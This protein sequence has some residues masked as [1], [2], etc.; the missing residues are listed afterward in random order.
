VFV[1]QINLDIDTRFTL[2]SA[3]SA[4]DHQKYHVD[5][6]NELTP[7]ALLFV[8]GRTLRAI[9][10]V[11]AIVMATRIIHGR[12]ISLEC[13]VVEMT[14]IRKGREFEDLD[15]TNKEEGIEKM[16]GAKG[17]FILWPHKDIILKT[18][19]SSILQNRED[20]GT[21]TSENTLRNN[22]GFTPPSQNPPQTAS[23]HEDPP[24]RQPLQHHSPPHVA[25]SKCSPHTTVTPQNFKFWNVTKIH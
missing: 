9:K 1:P 22:A 11:D 12:P 2:S 5:D 20:E 18:H 15:Y 13:A 17:N 10:V 7:C 6:I 24:P 25:V 21:P 14:T 8:K 4:P 16:K 3:S 23:P 19:Y